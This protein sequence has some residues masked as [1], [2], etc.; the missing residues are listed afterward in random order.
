MNGPHVLMCLNAYPLAR[1]TMKR[2]GLI[3]VGVALFK[4]VCHYGCR[5]MVSKTQTKPSIG[6]MSF[7]VAHGSGCRILNYVSSTVS[8]CILP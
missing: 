6:R 7:L 3:R 4:E 1:V 2:Q 5:L 8:V